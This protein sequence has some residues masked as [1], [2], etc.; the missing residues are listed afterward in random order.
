[1]SRRK[2]T[3]YNGTRKIQTV[4]TE[5]MKAVLI[6]VERLDEPSRFYAEDQLYEIRYINKQYR[7][8]ARSS[9]ETIGRT[10]L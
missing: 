4:I 9:D 6:L 1:M 5:R 8:S 3:G 2:V 10:E 7:V